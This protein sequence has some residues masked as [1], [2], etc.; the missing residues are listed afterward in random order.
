MNVRKKL[1]FLGDVRVAQV[2]VLERQLNLFGEKGPPK[3]PRLNK[4]A[5]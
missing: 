5:F 1:S 3:A 2:I 4:I